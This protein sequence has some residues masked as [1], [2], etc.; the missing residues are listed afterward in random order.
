MTSASYTVQGMTCGHCAASV[1]TELSKI[2]GVSD[3][4]V[5]CHRFAWSSPAASRSPTPRSPMR[6]RTPATRSSSEVC[7]P[8]EGLGVQS[9]VDGQVVVARP[10]VGA[11]HLSQHPALS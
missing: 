2:I 7:D 10:S 1:T 11:A 5:D 9:V 6:S 8:V 4:N 3:V